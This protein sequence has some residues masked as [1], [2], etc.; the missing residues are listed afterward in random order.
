[1]A[2]SSEFAA[3]FPQDEFEHNIRETMQMG[4]PEDDTEKLTWIW[5]RRKEYSP[6]DPAGHPYSWTATPSSDDPGNPDL[7]DP[8]AEV[9]QTLIV[10][11]AIEFSSRPAGSIITVFGEIDNSRAVITLLKVD[12]ETIKTAD[13]ASINGTRYRIQFTAPPQGLFG[14]TIET[15]ILEAIDE[16]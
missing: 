7:P 15:V 5:F 6:A 4:M 14:S 12:Y 9:E 1:M 3:E 11:Y 8:G 2:T 16:K 10:D 13:E